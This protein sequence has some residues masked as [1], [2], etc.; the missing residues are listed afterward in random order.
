[1]PSWREG[2]PNA[3]LEAMACGVA[4][5][6]SDCSPCMREIVRDGVDGL[7]V[8]PW[9][10]GPFAEGLNRLMSNDDERQRFAEHAREVVTRFSVEEAVARLD[11]IFDSQAAAVSRLHGRGDGLVPE[12]G[13]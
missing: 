7:V 1:M 2:F 12:H 13:G 5:V 9:R 3:L 8:T 10:I 4:P 6:V 11:R